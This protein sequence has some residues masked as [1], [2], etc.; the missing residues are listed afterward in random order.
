M[1]SQFTH[2][3]DTPPPGA[4]ADWTISQNWDAFT[5]DEH[6]MWDRLF[7]RQSD[8][9]PGRAADAF[10]RGIDV[11]RLEKPGIP[12]YRELNA[13]LMA[14][15]GWQVIAVP[16]LV[17][18]EVFFDHL[19]NRRFPAGNFI[20]TPEQLD[21]LQEPDVFHDVFGHVPMLADPVFADYMVAYGEGGLRSLKFDA[22]K[23]LARL[24][25]YTVEFGLI[26]EAGGLRIYGAGI[27]SSFAESVFALD[28]DS[29]NRIGFDLA[30]VMRTDYRIDDFQQ[31]YFVIDSLDQLLDT[32]V[33]TDF[34]PLYAKNAALPPIP[35]ADFLPEDEVITRGTQEYALAK[36]G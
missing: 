19:A 10:L 36:S 14:A 18:D 9:L 13:R 8:M 17:P 1:E 22:L 30:R 2:V 24:Y 21:Y 5:A 27:V 25:W 29:P 11:L 32:T 31:N 33:N 4:A 20:R 6:A 16:G 28:S 23:Q 7:A 35:I 34:A 3:H 15:T 12:D 26:R